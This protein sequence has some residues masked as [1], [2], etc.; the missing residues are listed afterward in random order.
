MKN[1]KWGE[2][3]LK[4]E[5]GTRGQCASTGDPSL[6]GIL[7]S[8]HIQM[9]AEPQKRRVKELGEANTLTTAGG[10]HC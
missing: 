5:D 3:I 9:K 10:C 6:Q 7:G 1:Q 4:E 8:K 2:K